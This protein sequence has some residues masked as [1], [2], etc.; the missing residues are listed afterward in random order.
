M[1]IR[2]RYQR[3]VHGEEAKKWITTLSCPEYVHIATNSLAKEEAKVINFLDVETR[4]ELTQALESK[5]IVNYA[6]Q[7]AQMEKTGVKVML[8][9][10]KIAELRAITNLFSKCKDQ[11]EHI[12]NKLLPYIVERGKSIRE[13]KEVVEDPV[14]Y[15]SK[16]VEFKKEMDLMMDEC[17]SGLE[18]FIKTNNMAFQAIMDDFD[19]TP[20]FMASYIDHLMRQ[21]L[22]GKEKESESMI[23]DIF[24]LFKLL[25]PKDAFTEH[26]KELYALRLLQHTSISDQL[27]ESLITKMKIELGAQHVSKYLQM[28]TDMQSSKTQ[29]EQ[30]KKESHRGIIGGVEMDIKILTSGLWGQDRNIRCK[31]PTELKGCCERFEH[32]YKKLH[33]GRHL[34]WNAGLGDCEVLASKFKKPYTFIT[35]VYQATILNLF[36]LKDSYTFEE[37]CHETLLPEEVMSKQMFNL[38]N[39]KFGKLLIK[40]NLKTPKFGRTEKIIINFGFSSVSLR[41]TMIPTIVRR[42]ALEEHQKENEAGIKEVNKQRCAILQATVVK[43]M[44]GRRQE[45]HNELIREV[46][47]QVNAFRPDPIMIKQQIEWLIESDY[48]MRDEKDRSKYIY[49]P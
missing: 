2:D 40:E 28:G 33:S 41:M 20:K 10:K 22:R 21:G 18:P 14:K 39:P 24:G 23:E 16:L 4:P 15:M 9:N 31:L 43:I 11:L 27:E 49:K 8:Q 7:L 3:R 37:L 17:F 19:L 34:V 36:N 6:Q 5:I 25:K 13:T 32:F 42:K 12:L 1:C 47:K 44:K 48:L 35:T 38:T 30:F 29:T 45:S 26:H 46:V